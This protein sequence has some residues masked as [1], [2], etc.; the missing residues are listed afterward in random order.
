G[1]LGLGVRAYVDVG[2][3]RHAPHGRGAGE[4]LSWH[5]P[6][7]HR[8]PAVRPTDGLPAVAVRPARG[9]GAPARRPRE[10]H[11]GRPVR[12]APDQRPPRTQKTARTS[13]TTSAP[14]VSGAAPIRSTTG[15]STPIDPSARARPGP[16]ARREPSPP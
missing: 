2:G 9:R 16:R 10:A 15:P 4:A 1:G 11:H 3:G 13:P 7:A 8:V 14:P 6:G 5:F 12:R